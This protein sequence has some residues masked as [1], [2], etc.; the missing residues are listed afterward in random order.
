MAN[1]CS[2]C[3]SMAAVRVLAVGNVYP[4]HLLGGY[5]VIW[6]GAMRHLRSE[7][8]QGRVLTTDYRRGDVPADANEDPEVYRELSWYWRDH[9]WLSLSP[10][11]RFRLER[12]NAAVFDRHLHEF[13][14]DVITWWPVGGMSLGL[15]ELARRA[16]IPSLLFVLDYWPH[17]GPVHDLW[18]RMWASHRVA[19]AVVDRVTGLPTRPRL[20]EA[21][22]WLF[23]SR[24]MR[25]ETL[26]TG[27]R[28]SDLTILPAGVDNMFLRAGR[29]PR[30]PDWQWRLAYIGRVVEQKGVRTA[31]EALTRLPAQ[32]TLRIVGE[33]DAAYR[34]ELERLAASLGVAD[35]VC[36][37]PPQ[38]GAQLI[39][40]YRAADVIV[41]P[42]QWAEPFGLVPLEAMALGRPVVATGR[43]GSGDYLADGENSL[44]FT[45]GDASALAAALDRLAG[46]PDL[47]ERLRESGFQTAGRHGEDEFNRRAL[48]EV[49]TCARRARNGDSPP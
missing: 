7:G 12:R 42:V 11:E 49:L 18:T 14:P 6:R 22:R 43:G 28:I 8:H 41:F 19:G 40:A 10:R 17:Y 44:L 16:G 35:R 48:Q 9:E 33:G 47:R 30:A 46:D 34:R 27:L 45:A 1:A 36:F 23:C 26:A 32:A 24:S 21:G 39:G 29:E 5:E 25:D 13:R 20:E 38:S 4:P 2:E 15:L 37:D 3:G 31:I